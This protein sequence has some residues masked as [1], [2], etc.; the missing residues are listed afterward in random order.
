V[1]QTLNNLK[2]KM[3]P[4]TDINKKMTDNILYPNLTNQYF[5]LEKNA[6][7]LSGLIGMFSK[8]L[9]RIKNNTLHIRPAK[10]GIRYTSSIKCPISNKEEQNRPRKINPNNITTG[11]NHWSLE[12][13]ND[14]VSSIMIGFNIVLFG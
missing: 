4:A 1:N 3:S 13:M 8:A 2:L 12:E 14:S 9:I 11:L 10:L 5:I 6:N 7:F